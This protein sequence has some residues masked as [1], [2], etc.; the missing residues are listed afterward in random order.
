[1]IITIMIPLRIALLE[2]IADDFPDLFP[3]RDQS[4]TRRRAHQPRKAPVDRNASD[5]MFSQAGTP[6]PRFPSHIDPTNR[7]KS[8]QQKTSS[9]RSPK[10]REQELDDIIDN[11]FNSDDPGE[12]WDQEDL[13]TQ[14]APTMV[15]RVPRSRV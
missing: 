8:M 14:I 9:M 12:S 11:A 6:H 1:M 3:Q 7:P 5:A 10:S 4:Q 13:G 2:G 15:K